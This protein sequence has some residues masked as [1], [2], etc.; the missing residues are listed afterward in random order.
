MIN[1]RESRMKREREGE[2]KPSQFVVLLRAKNNHK[3][4]KKQQPIFLR[5]RRARRMWK[6]SVFLSWI[7]GNVRD[8]KICVMGAQMDDDDESV[9]WN[10]ICRQVSRAASRTIM[11][12]RTQQNTFFF[13][14]WTLSCVPVTC[15]RRRR[16]LI[17]VK[18]LRNEE[19]EA[20]GWWRSGKRTK[21]T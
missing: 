21:I 11:G 17:C 3:F 20:F 18:E 19:L 9:E 16:P 6:F 15:V 8:Q 2:G 13:C 4:E 10:G 1:E 14:W 12:R 7:K 5:E